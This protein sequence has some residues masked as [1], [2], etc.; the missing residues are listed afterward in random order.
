MRL[1][2]SGVDPS[3]SH[4]LSGDGAKGLRSQRGFP[5]VRVQGGQGREVVNTRRRVVQRQRI[6]DRWSS[7]GPAEETAQGRQATARSACLSPG[8]PKAKCPSH[9]AQI[10]LRSRRRAAETSGTTSGCPQ[11]VAEP[12]LLAEYLGAFCFAARSMMQQCSAARKR[13]NKSR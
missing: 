12:L 8:D 4:R 1:A 13:T 6:L 7:G 3:R 9:P 10:F 2:I 11:T 5:L